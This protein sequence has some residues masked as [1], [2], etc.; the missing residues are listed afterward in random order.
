[1]GKGNNH[2]LVIHSELNHLKLLRSFFDEIFKEYKISESNLNRF[3]LC[4]SEGV[5][6]AVVHGNNSDSEKYVKVNVCLQGNEITVEVSDEGDGFNFKD[7]PNP[8]CIE[9]IKKEAGRG[10]FIIQSYADKVD[11]ENNGSTLKFKF[12]LSGDTVLQ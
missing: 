7:I 3:L 11:F 8:T 4:V 5:T 9:N 12:N 1:M 10:L 6:N 2:T